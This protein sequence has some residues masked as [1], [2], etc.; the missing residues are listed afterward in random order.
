MKDVK[1]AVVCF[2]ITSRVLSCD[3]AF[4]VNDNPPNLIPAVFHGR[5]LFFHFFQGKIYSFPGL[6]PKPQY[7]F[8][9]ILN[10]CST[11]F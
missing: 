1:L 3:S 7:S 5:N 6:D 4:L 11:S 2:P 10:Q 8:S 9:T